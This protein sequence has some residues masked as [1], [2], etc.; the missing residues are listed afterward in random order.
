LARAL[1]QAG[2]QPDLTRFTNFT[3]S[4]FEL[5]FDRLALA[6]LSPCSGRR[7]RGHLFRAHQALRPVLLGQSVI[8]GTTVNTLR[9]DP[10][11]PKGNARKSRTAVNSALVG[12]TT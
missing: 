4:G 7:A 2:W 3:L 12:A 8:G 11:A 10:C 6:F 9:V 1:A 5:S